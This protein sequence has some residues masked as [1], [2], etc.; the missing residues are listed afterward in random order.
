MIYE[1]IFCGKLRACTFFNSGKRSGKIS[2]IFSTKFKLWKNVENSISV[3][4]QKLFHEKLIVDCGKL[5][6]REP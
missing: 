3:W 6:L 5:P 4:K 2:N 1:K